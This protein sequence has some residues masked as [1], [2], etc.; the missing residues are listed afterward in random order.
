M[1]AFELDGA[2]PSRVGDDP[3]FGTGPLD[4]LFGGP[5][6]TDRTAPTGWRIVRWPTDPDPATP[7]WFLDARRDLVSD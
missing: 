5:G 2:A 3:T 1:R 4:C 6:E 7:L